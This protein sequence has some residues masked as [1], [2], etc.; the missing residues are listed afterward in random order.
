MLSFGMEYE[1]AFSIAFASARLA[2]GSGPPSRAAT[3][4]ARESFEKSWPRFLSAAPFLCLME[5]HLLC[6][7]I[8]L[9]PYEVEKPLVHARVVGQLRVKRRHQD[10]ALAQQHGLAVELGKHVDVRS[11]LRDPRRADEDASQR[12]LVTVEVEVGLEARHLAA[13]GVARDLEVDH[14]EV[15]AVEQDHPRTG[16]EDG[17]RKPPDRILE[18][19][20]PDEPHDRGRLSARD[21][22]AVEPVELLRLAHFD[23]LRAK[24]AQHRRV[25]AE[26]PL[27]RQDAD[28]HAEKSSGALEELRARDGLSTTPR[29]HERDRDED[30]AGEAEHEP[31]SPWVVRPALPVGVDRRADQ[32]REEIEGAVED[33]LR[34]LGR[35]VRGRLEDPPRAE[36]DPARAQEPVADREVQQ[37]RDRDQ[38]PLPVPV[39]EE[40]DQPAADRQAGHD[41]QPEAVRA[42]IREVDR[43]RSREQAEPHE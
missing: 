20:Q 12:P 1:R 27:Y 43:N 36:D 13:I 22:Q 38:D 37:A 31:R 29:D 25:L 35:E 33:V 42:S 24:P 14:T 10:A 2:A 30:R 7:D 28:S 6:P 11:H 3:I 32:E 39:V 9:L 17:P 40:P 4:S 23:R 16:A 41:V 26:V 18:S 19:V 34:P 15:V 5:L 8:R 21:D